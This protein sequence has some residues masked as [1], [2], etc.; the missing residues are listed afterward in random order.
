MPGM[1]AEDGALLATFLA[2]RD[3]ASFLVLY[4]AHTPYLYR[5]ALRLLGG[6]RADAEDAVQDAWLRATPRLAGFRGESALRTW[7]AAFAINCCRER[8]RR[9]GPVL[10]DTSPRD[11]ETP[12]A[13][14]PP[15]ED[16]LALEQAIARLPDGCREILVLHDLEGYTHE[17]IAG[18]LGIVA[19][20]SK[21]QLARARR[22]HRAAHAG[23]AVP[24]P[25]GQG[26][27]T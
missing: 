23:A 27:E 25:A 20:T 22:R 21:S 19:G 2:R 1:S 12:G 18:R 11:D 8:L 14:V 17:E 16:R 10:E 7:L 5:L 9:R 24:R 13:A 4:R 15:E 26:V 3:E 6:R